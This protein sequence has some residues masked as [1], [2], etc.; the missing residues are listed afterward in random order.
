MK[1]SPR[2]VDL[3][4]SLN[5]D[6]EA[7]TIIYQIHIEQANKVGDQANTNAEICKSDAFSG[8]WVNTLTL[9]PVRVST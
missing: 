8:G 3:Q 7:V 5:W 1:S 4:I 2:Y 6:T 9:V